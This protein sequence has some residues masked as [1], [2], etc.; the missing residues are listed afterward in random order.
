MSARVLKL[1]PILFHLFENRAHR[2]LPG[3]K[4][5]TRILVNILSQELLNEKVETKQ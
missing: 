5:Y 4:F 2:G 3:E 1:L